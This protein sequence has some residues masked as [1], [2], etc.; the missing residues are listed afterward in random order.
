MLK[1]ESPFR[2]N[3]DTESGSE[4]SSTTAKSHQL[5]KTTLFLPLFFSFFSQSF[6][7]IKLLIILIN[8]FDIENKKKRSEC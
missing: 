2:A 5:P 6:I 1:D 4:S 7:K 3:R 8:N